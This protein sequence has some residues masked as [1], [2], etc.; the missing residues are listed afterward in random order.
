[1]RHKFLVMLV[2]AAMLLIPLAALAQDEAPATPAVAPEQAAPTT[3]VEEAY[4]V[5]SSP[6][7]RVDA[8]FDAMM[9]AIPYASFD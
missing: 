9:D 2:A 7:G 4:S 5:F 3:P 8:L 6:P 1:M